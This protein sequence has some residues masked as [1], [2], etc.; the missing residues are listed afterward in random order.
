[1]F[2]FKQWHRA[3]AAAMVAWAGMLAAQT[4]T[5]RP[6]TI[7]QLIDV[8]HPSN[9]VWSPDGKRVAFLWDRADVVNLYVANSDG[10]SEPV[11]LTSYPEGKVG[12][13]FW[14]KDSSTIYF[15]RGGDLWQGAAVGGQP[16]R[17][18]WT[19]PTAEVEFSPSP[20]RTRV[21]FVRAGSV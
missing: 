14:S 21:A 15:S 16:P 5:P 9:P 18:V 12:D 7:E 8:K 3:L 10:T 17:A 13:V 4:K 6:L 19:T 11:A 20:D 1:M 2:R